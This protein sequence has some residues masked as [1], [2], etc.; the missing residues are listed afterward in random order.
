MLLNSNDKESQIGAVKVMENLAQIDIELIPKIA[1]ADT[2]R[3]L[4]MKLETREPDQY[5]SAIKCLS[6]FSVS[7]ESQIIKLMI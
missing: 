3:K 6:A 4:F 1:S 5:S 7:S 2:I